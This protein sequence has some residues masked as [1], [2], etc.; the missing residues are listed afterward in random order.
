MQAFGAPDDLDSEVEVGGGPGLQFAGVD[1]IGPGVADP[2]AGPV[3]VEQ[4]RAGRI[5]VLHG[6]G[7][8]QHL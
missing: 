2:P 1:G 4:Q 5:A 6:R 8:G 7:S 3:Q